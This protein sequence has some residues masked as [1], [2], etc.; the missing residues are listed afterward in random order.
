MHAANRL[1]QTHCNIC[2]NHD[3]VQKPNPPES[4]VLK[5]YFQVI[6][7]LLVV[8]VAV[9]DVWLCLCSYAGSVATMTTA[10]GESTPSMDYLDQLDEFNIDY[11]GLVNLNELMG[12]KQWADISDLFRRLRWFYWWQRLML[13]DIGKLSI[14]RYS[15]G[16][17]DGFCQ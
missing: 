15:W 11:N 14:A 7:F 17:T 9:C 13:H 1:N 8:C 10:A 2:L 6:S 12:Y 5:T 16:I 3:L 4:L